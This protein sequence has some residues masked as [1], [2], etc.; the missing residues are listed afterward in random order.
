MNRLQ[1][2]WLTFNRAKA[3]QNVFGTPGNMTPDQEI[4]IRLLA[5]LCH[6]NSSSVAISP[7]TQQTDPYA[8]FVSEGRREVFLHIN[9]YLGL[10]QSEISALIAKEMNELNE[11]EN[12][13]SV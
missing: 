6:V 5:K 13:E 8:V 1:S 3:F 9:H 2:L 11:D 4:V 10:S 7:T 12:N